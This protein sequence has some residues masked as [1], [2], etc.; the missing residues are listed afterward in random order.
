MLLESEVDR[1]RDKI[2]EVDAPDGERPDALRNAAGLAPHWKATV[3]HPFISKTYVY[4]TMIR[5]RQLVSRPLRLR[6]AC[7]AAAVFLSCLLVGSD[8]SRAD[9]D[10]QRQLGDFLATAIPLAT[11]GTELYRGDKDGA[12]QYAMT[13]AVSAAT[14]DVLGRLTHVERPDGS[15][16]NS[17]PSGH[18]ARVFS[19]AAYVRRRHGFDVAWPLYLAGLYVGYTRVAADRHRW[20][21]IA[22]AALVSELSAWW[23]VE[24]ESKVVVMPAVGHR[25]VGVHIAARW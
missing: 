15:N 25:Y 1:P 17:F 3:Q 9:T 14:T 24:P 20:G 13:F 11:L 6:H 8:E 12:W 10:S 5:V 16:D 2:N 23:L 21:D 4:A 19:S 7:V 18:A 22:G